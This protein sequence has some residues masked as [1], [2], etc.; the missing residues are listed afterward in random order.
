MADKHISQD[1]RNA[2]DGLLLDPKVFTPNY[3]TGQEAEG[4]NLWT[5]PQARIWTLMLFLGTCLLFCARMAMPICAV[6]MA[7]TFHWSKTES[8]LVLGGFFWGYCFTQILGGHASDK[9]GGE[10]VLFLSTASW[11][12][13]TAATPLLAPLG[14]HP[15]ALMTMARFL[16]G[17][18]QGAHYPS[19]AS[20]CSQRVVEGERGFLMSIMHSGCYLGT[21][22]VGGLGSL[23]LE[24]YGWESVFYCTGFLSALWALTV[25]QLLLKGQVIPKQM[26]S[27][28]GPVSRIRWLSLLKRPPVCAMVFAHMCVS[29]S[30]Y[31]LLSWLPS[32]FE[33]TFPHA[34]GWVYNVVPWLVAIPSVLGGGYVSDFLINQGYGVASVRK[35]MQFVAMGASSTFILLLCRPVTFSSTLAF[36]SAAMSLTTFTSSGVGINVQDLAPSCAGALFG[37]MNMCGAFSG[38]VMVSVSGYLIEVTLS[39]ATVFSLI[40]LINVTGLGFFLV[41]GDARRVD[42]EDY[43]R[44]TLI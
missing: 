11:A 24:W 22:L 34:M 42:L 28:R 5:R 25:W 3:A 36:V 26:L 21:L 13:I 14:G 4:Q 40:T 27:S 41:F 7:N 12:A 38:L 10:R 39:W 37:F 33:D 19:L 30:S 31:T 1:C 23:M 18:L 15:L 20:L 32:F 6:S 43:S 29:S 35:I 44:V 8:G 16:M 17:L 9:V 2:F